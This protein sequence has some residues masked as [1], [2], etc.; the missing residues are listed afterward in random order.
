MEERYGKLLNKPLLAG[1][2]ARRVD[3]ALAGQPM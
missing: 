2:F 1:R 3:G